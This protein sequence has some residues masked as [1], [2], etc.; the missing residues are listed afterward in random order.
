M[1]KTKKRKKDKK[2][3]KDKKAKAPTTAEQADKYVLY[4]LSVQE[5]EHEV[6][7]FDRIYKS[8][9][10]RSPRVL[11]EDF[12]GTFAVACEWV[13]LGPKR[14]ALGVDLDPEPLDW[15]RSHNLVG[16]PEKSRDRVT[17]R[18]AD[19]L[20]I[21]PADD[22]PKADVLAAQNF[23]FWIFTTRDELRGYFEAAYANLGD[24]GVMVLDMMGGGECYIENNVDV[25]EIEVPD[26]VGWVPKTFDYLWEQS[27]YNPIRANASFYIHFRFPDGSSMEK[28]FAYH[29]RFWTLPEVRE[30]LAEA[31]FDE[32]YVYW[33]GTDDDTGEGDGQWTRRE[34]AES[35]PSWIAY[36]AAV[37]RKGE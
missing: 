19:V 33:E 30:L 23:S 11:R 17:L 26:A 4:Q 35:D 20:H 3:R 14:L 13:K 24:E 15:G 18:Q 21:T 31:G 2:K 28:A 16:V 27:T 34:T 9:F 32:T 37:K 7:F 25:R 8:E 22:H 6:E 5:P 1:P 12:C 36:V 10:G 29:W